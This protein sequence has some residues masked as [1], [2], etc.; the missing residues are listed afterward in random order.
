MDLQLLIYFTFIP[1]LKNIKLLVTSHFTRY[2]NV[3]NICKNIRVYVNF[4]HHCLCSYVTLQ[5]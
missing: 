2:M 5:L 1:G 4:R 3:Y